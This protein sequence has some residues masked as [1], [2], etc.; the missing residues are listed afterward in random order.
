MPMS[1]PFSYSQSCIVV[2]L[3]SHACLFATP[4][5]VAHQAPLSIVFPRQEYWSGLPFPS[6]GDLPDPRIKLASPALQADSLQTELRGSPFFFLYHLSFSEYP[7]AS[8][9]QLS[10]CRILPTSSPAM[11]VLSAL[12]SF[13]QLTVILPVSKQQSL[14]S[15]QQTLTVCL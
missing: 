6:S 11:C 10:F 3:V 5:T 13:T 8:V 4:W 2:Q 15:V 9:I 12:P 14:Q 1:S 7:K